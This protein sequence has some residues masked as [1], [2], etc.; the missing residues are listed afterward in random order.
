MIIN[1]LFMFESTPDVYRP[2]EI[3]KMGKVTYSCTTNAKRT[4]RVWPRY[5]H[6]E[7]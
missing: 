2:F 7:K 1:R 5:A 4:V 3:N 6:S